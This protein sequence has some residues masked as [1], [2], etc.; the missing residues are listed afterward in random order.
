MKA[1]ILISNE[2][3]VARARA[4]IQLTNLLFKCVRR[5]ARR[6]PCPLRAGEGCRDGCSRCAS[7]RRYAQMGA[8]A[9]P[10]FGK[11]A[12]AVTGL[13]GDM[14]ENYMV[15]QNNPQERQNAAANIIADII[16]VFVYPVSAVRAHACAAL[17]PA[18]RLTSAR[19]LLPPGRHQG[20]RRGPRPQLRRG[21]AV[22]RA[23][24]GR[25]WP[26]GGRAR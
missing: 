16:S 20:R 23:G 3:R 24:C 10:T 17:G 12:S 9:I 1:Q 2:Q 19:R 18:P 5:A 7:A 15:N 21:R 6:R 22:R 13:V 4:K 11:I 26:D 14:I 25:R 8:S